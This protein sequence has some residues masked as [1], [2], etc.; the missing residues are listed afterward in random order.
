MTYPSSAKKIT[1]VNEFDQK[2]NF[3]GPKGLQAVR[4]VIARLL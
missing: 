1:F 3:I 2:T 4:N